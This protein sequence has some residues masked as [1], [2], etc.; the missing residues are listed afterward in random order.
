MKVDEWKSRTI[1]A[2]LVHVEHTSWLVLRKLQGRGMRLVPG[3]NTGGP[4]YL[5]SRPCHQTHSVQPL[6]PIDHLAPPAIA[7]DRALAWRCPRLA[8][9]H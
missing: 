4:A 8:V 7:Q 3:R 1:D 5:H 6:A 9:A 2:G